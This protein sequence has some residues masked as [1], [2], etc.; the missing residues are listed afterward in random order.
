VSLEELDTALG[1]GG[2]L[3][4]VNHW[5]TWCS[6]CVEELPELGRLHRTLGDRVQ[7]LGLSWE[8]FQTTVSMDQS[9][10]DLAETMERHGLRW[11]TLVLNDGVKPETFFAQLELE[12]QT[13]P[14]TWL[15]DDSGRVLFQ[16]EAVLDAA[17]VDEIVSKVEAL[18]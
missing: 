16:V 3:R 14:Q 1:P 15:V 17:A 2:G 7:F 13:V 4:I 10:K 8:R 18:G 6:G 9:L 5:A 11:P 12:C